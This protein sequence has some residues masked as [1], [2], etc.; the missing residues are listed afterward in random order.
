MSSFRNNI[1][2]LWDYVSPRK[3][4]ERRDKPFKAPA[5]P[6][7]LKD[8]ALRKTSPEMDVDS[9]LDRWDGKAAAPASEDHAFLPPSP[10]SSVSR[11]ED[12]EIASLIHDSVEDEPED[13]KWDANEETLVL[14]DSEFLEKQKPIDREKEM[15]ALEAQAISLRK[16]GWEEDALFLFQKL[17]SRG[18]E[19]LFLERWVNDFATLPVDLFT[20][21]DEQAFIKPDGGSDFRGM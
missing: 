5:L 1:G 2:R 15:L 14:E 18:F 12:A 10:P 16:A 4:R 17:N 13:D 20:F 21:N 3:T 6:T 19:P 9:K 7:P 11:N 8:K